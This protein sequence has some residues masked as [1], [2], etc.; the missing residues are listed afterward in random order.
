MSE[1]LLR[2]IQ[3]ATEACKEATRE[4]H[5]LLKDLKVARRDI[6]QFLSGNPVQQVQDRI[7]GEVDRQIDRFIR[8]F[9]QSTEGLLK[10]LNT[11]IASIDQ[12]LANAFVIELPQPEP[13]TRS[14]ED[15]R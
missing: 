7:D 11:R 3:Q 9:D 2:K 6:E 13:G 15:E 5:G 14:R 12:R 1:E 4:A 10:S 8:R